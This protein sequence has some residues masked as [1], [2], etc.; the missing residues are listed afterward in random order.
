[1]EDNDYFSQVSLRK[2]GLVSLFISSGKNALLFL[3]TDGAG[4]FGG[5][6]G[7]ETLSQREIYALHLAS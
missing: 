4:D 2:L 1:M 7:Q 5:Q 3:V 6:G